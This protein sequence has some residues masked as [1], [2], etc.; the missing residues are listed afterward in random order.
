MPRDP[1]EPP[2]APLEDPRAGRYTLA[3]RGR[4]LVNSL[5]DQI[6]MGFV[7]SLLVAMVAVYVER[8]PDSLL[9]SDL[10]VTTFGI[11]AA[12]LYYV[13]CESLT[14]RTL[15]K[16]LTGTRTVTVSGGHPSFGQILLRTLVRFFPLEFLTFLGK[17]P[18]GFHDRWSGT[19]VVRS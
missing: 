10:N 1:F 6:C 9:D 5:I 12:V 15:G 14:G 13:S 7:A 8:D 3:S 4:R 18:I 17:D 16:L 19:R 11:A 2:S